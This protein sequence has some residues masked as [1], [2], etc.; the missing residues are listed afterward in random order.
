MNQIE[1]KILD[2][3]KEVVPDLTLD[4]MTEE[5]TFEEVGINSINFIAIVISLEEHFDIEITDELL[6]ME[7][8]NTIKKI[9]NILKTYGI[10]EV[11]VLDE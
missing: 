7:N 1:N 10:E 4:N 5:L 11:S 6:I 9:E 8:M 3:I 2:I